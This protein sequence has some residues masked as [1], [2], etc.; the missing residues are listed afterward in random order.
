M[1]SMDHLKGCRE[2]EGANKISHR[3]K[4]RINNLI[5]FLLGL[6]N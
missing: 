4:R 2:G 1:V 3:Q 5:C 6:N